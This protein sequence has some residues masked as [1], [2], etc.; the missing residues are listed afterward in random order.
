MAFKLLNRQNFVGY[1]ED[2]NFCN[3]Q[4]RFVTFKRI[5][6]TDFKSAQAQ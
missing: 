6:T 5:F 3:N 4:R 2:P 1:N